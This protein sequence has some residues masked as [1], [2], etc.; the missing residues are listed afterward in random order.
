MPPQK[1]A[2]L[3]RPTFIEDALPDN[4]IVT[5]TD[6]GHGMSPEDVEK[7][8]LPINRNRRKDNSGK[9]TQTKTEAGKRYVMGRKGIGKLSAFGA[10][11]LIIVETKRAGQNYET[12][13][14]LELTKLR[15][16]TNLSDVT[17]PALY[18]EGVNEKEHGTKVTLAKLKCDSMK[19][20]LADL[21]D[22][23]SEAFF[24]IREEEFSIQ[25]N[26]SPIQR[27]EVKY[28]FIWPTDL[29]NDGMASQ[30]VGTPEIGEINFKF[31]VKFREE[32]LPASKRG[33]R[34]YCNKRLALGPTLLN[35]NTGTHNF[36]AHQYME[37]IVEADDLD[38]QNV[39]LIS[40]DRGDVRRNNDLVDAFI[41][42]LTELM[43]ESVKAHSKY[44]DTVADEIIEKDPR[45]EGVRR[46]ISA[47]PKSQRASG[48]KIVNVIVARHGI[49]SPEFST[50][51]PLLVQ[52]MNAGEVLV[53]LIKASTNPTDVTDLAFHI[54]ELRD[55][56]K[57]DA[58]K[59][60]RARKNGIHGLRVLTDKAED[61]WLKGKKTESELH[62]LLKYAPWLIKPELAGF[63]A[64]DVSMD[65]VVTVLAKN[66]SID[67]FASATDKDKIETEK[68]DSTRPDLV[69]LLSDAKQPNKIL[70]VELK[71]PNIPL[72]RKHLSQLETYMRKVE[73]WH[74]S[75]FSGQSRHL[76]VEGVL[77]G[78]MPDSKTTADGARDLL[79]TIKKNMGSSRWEVC[80]LRELL[81]RT[82]AV[83]RELIEAI[84]EEDAD[85]EGDD[86]NGN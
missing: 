65:K 41:A 17:I 50:I 37:F 66:L 28:E 11:S 69:F 79:D 47:L 58:L 22:A 57:N 67:K 60:Y 13:F 59:I 24:P 80:G 10:S 4:L 38:R 51:A 32:S 71:S 9:E 45:A 73:E 62:E 74:A 72:E 70:V 40:T 34:I 82:E 30:K 21:E 68:S 76:I 36:M 49:E 48:K 2:G 52:T 26:G 75:E 61:E 81:A 20:N 53:D 77:I 64:S 14:D 1:K 56:E 29:D 78:A 18:K 27:S 5:V 33:A 43:V 19:F 31:V 16:E 55:I 39:D 3:S 84:E 83:H 7:K 86:I 54:L 6:K 8:Y 12:R 42:R 25:I 85:K 46:I 35:L 23:L 44:R 63:I 15:N